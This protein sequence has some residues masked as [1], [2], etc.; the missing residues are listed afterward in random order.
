MGNN[1]ST[2]SN[3]L[4][5]KNILEISDAMGDAILERFW[6]LEKSADYLRTIEGST[7]ESLKGQLENLRNKFRSLSFDIIAYDI[8]EGRERIIAR[9]F[10]G[11]E[12]YVS[13]NCDSYVSNIAK[14]YRKYIYKNF[15][16]K[17]LTQDLCDRIDRLQSSNLKFLL[18]IIEYDIDL[19]TTD[20]KLYEGYRSKMI[21]HILRNVTLTN[22]PAIFKEHLEKVLP[23]LLTPDRI[24]TYPSSKIIEYYRK[25]ALI[26]T[27]NRLYIDTEI[28]ASIEN[29]SSDE[30]GKAIELNQNPK[31]PK[32]KERL[33]PPKL[34]GM[35]V[36]S[37]T[38][39]MQ[40]EKKSE[41]SGSL[42]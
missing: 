16:K 15:P 41:R 24:K 36:S 3:M 9:T 26:N 10:D 20:E 21:D 40:E 22:G 12:Y 42:P 18:H 7:V 39:S 25:Y 17:E 37:G 35:K 6:P 19:S 33:S 13:Q 4:N 1:V 8:K 14:Y 30:L 32:V 31:D 2:S 38:A 11:G 34:P 28:L 29:L 5:K 23:N 27:N